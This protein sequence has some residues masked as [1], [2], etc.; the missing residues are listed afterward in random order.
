MKTKAFQ[1]GHKKVGGRQKGTPNRINGDVRDRILAQVTPE[2]IISDIQKVSDPGRRAE[3]KM[4]LLEFVVPK[5]QRVTIT[6]N[7]DK[8]PKEV[9]VS[10][11]QSIDVTDEVETFS[12]LSPDRQRDILKKAKVKVK[13]RGSNNPQPQRTTQEKSDSGHGAHHLIQEK[14]KE[15]IQP[16]PRKTSGLETINLSGINRSWNDNDFIIRG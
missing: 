9:V 2:E 14:P 10:F 16:E 11:L 6:N 3:L 4:R 13:S 15:N 7:E 5:P 8:Q 1:K 12:N